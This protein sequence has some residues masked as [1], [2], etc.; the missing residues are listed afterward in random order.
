MNLIQDGKKGGMLQF[1]E[2]V[3]HFFSVKI[4]QEFTG[5]KKYRKNTTPEIRQ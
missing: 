4:S 5:L 1:T 2:M 3:I